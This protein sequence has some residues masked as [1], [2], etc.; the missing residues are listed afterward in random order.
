M[1]TRY[2][3]SRRPTFQL[4]FLLVKDSRKFKEYIFGFNTLQ[5]FGIKVITK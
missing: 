3:H 4:L 1:Y 2:L 5:Y